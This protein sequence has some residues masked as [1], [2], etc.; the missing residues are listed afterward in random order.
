MK[1]PCISIPVRSAP[2]ETPVKEKL[3]IW[4]N[5]R[6]GGKQVTPVKNNKIFITRWK[7]KKT[8]RLPRWKS[9][10]FGLPGGNL[11]IM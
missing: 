7:T 1:H 10:Q 5:L 11:E 8:I 4:Q 9:A 3:K 2:V 6:S